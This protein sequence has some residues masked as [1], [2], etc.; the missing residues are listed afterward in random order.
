MRS[1]IRNVEHVLSGIHS[2][3][4]T[5]SA[6]SILFAFFPAM[7]CGQSRPAVKED[8]EPEKKKRR[9]S[10][11]AV[12]PPNIAM[13]IGSNVKIQPPPHSKIFV[14]FGKSSNIII[15]ITEMHNST[16]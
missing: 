16:L 11:V 3:E 4:I 5:F 1:L 14:I 10:V 2:N 15:Q 13:N 7:G 8:T 12:P 9:Q 6:R